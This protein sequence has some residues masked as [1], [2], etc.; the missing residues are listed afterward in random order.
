MELV[1]GPTLADRIAQGPIP[2]E[3]ALRLAKQIAEALEARARAGPRRSTGYRICSLPGRQI[4]KSG[5][6]WLRLDRRRMH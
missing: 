2:T 6:Q 3:E 4:W 1:E 5:F